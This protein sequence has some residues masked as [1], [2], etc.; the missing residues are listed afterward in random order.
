MLRSRENIVTFF[1]ADAKVFEV[2][3]GLED[4]SD[5]GI[6]SY[7]LRLDN[8]RNFN[9]FDYLLGDSDLN[10]SY[11]FGLR[12]DSLLGDLPRDTGTTD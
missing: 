5:E 6:G 11:D 2:D 8:Y 4:H 10:S 7:D 1:G 9:F 12:A 3:S